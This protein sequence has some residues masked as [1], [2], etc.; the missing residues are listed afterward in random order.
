MRRKRRMLLP[1]VLACSAVFLVESAH[2]TGIDGGYVGTD[3][4]L[5]CHNGSPASDQT[6]F[7]KTGHPWKYKHTGGGSPSDPLSGLFPTPLI[8]TIQTTSLNDL[9]EGTP[10][11]AWSAIN[12]TIGGYG[13]KIRWG[14]LDHGQDSDGVNETGY[15][16]A[17]TQAQ[18]NIETGTWSGY[19]A[20]L[21]SNKK[22]ECATCHNTNGIVSTAGYS[23]WTDPGTDAAPTRTEPWGSNPGMGPDTHGGYYSSWT[24]DGVQCEG[25][26]GKGS[27]AGNTGH[28]NLG[29][30]ATQGVLTIPGPG[31]TTVE[32]CAK[33]HVRAENTASTGAE[34]GGD[35]NPAIL[36]NGAKIT[37]PWIGHHEQYNELTG[38]NGDG[39]HASLACTTC[40]D[41]HKRAAG[42][43]GAV[44][45]ALGISGD[46]T[47]SETGAIKK[48][49]A[50]CHGAQ[51]AADTASAVAKV[52]AHKNAGVTCVDCHMAEAT[53]TAT[54]SSTAGWGRKADLKTHIFKIDPA[55][56]SIVRPNGFTNVAQNYISPK[57]ACGKCH[58]SNI[59]G[60]AIA[61]PTSEAEAQ[62]AAADYHNVTGIDGGYV[63]S[64]ACSGCHADHYGDFVKSGHPYKVRT[65]NGATPNP[66]TDPL[67]ALLTSSGNNT[68][69]AVAALNADASLPIAQIDADGDGKLDW[70]SVQYV[71]G[72]FGWKA[73]WGILDSGTDCDQATYNPSCGTGYVWSAASLV[74]GYG[75]QFNM[76]AA[77]ITL[78]PTNKRADWS[79]YGSATGQS[80]KY[81]C[82]VCH[83]TNGKITSYDPDH[84]DCKASDVVATRTQPWAS[85]SLSF[86]NHGGFYSEWTFDGVQCEAC[87]GPAIDHVK[88]PSAS[89]IEKD[90]TKEACGKCH[91][92]ATN[93]AVTLGGKNDECGGD[94]NPEYLI[95]GA[96]STAGDFN[97]H[98]EQ[99]NELVGVTG[100]GAHAS[101]DC[102]DCHDPH[103][104]SHKVT[105]AIA[106]ALAI[107]DNEESAEDRGAVVSCE[108]C[109]GSKIL[110]YSMPGVECVDCHMA[111]VT[112]SGTG[113]KGAWGKMGDVK[114][115][116]FKIDPSQILNTRTNSA[117]KVVATNYLT[118]DYACGKCHDSSLSTYKFPALT[119][120]AAQQFAQGMHSAHAPSCAVTFSYTTVGL[121]LNPVAS[122]D[123][124]GAFTYDWD[125]GD[126]NS[127]PN[128]GATPPGHTYAAAGWHCTD[129]ISPDKATCQANNAVWTNT[130]TKSITLTVSNSEGTVGSVTRSVTVTAPDLP[131]TA[132]GSCTANNNT[133][134]ATLDTN[135]SSDDNGTPSVIVYWGDGSKQAVSA[136]PITH[137][138]V[139]AGSYTV[140]L[141][142]I[143]SAL[144]VNTSA[145]LCTAAP[146]PFTIGGTVY[147]SDG[148][149]PVASATVT[150]KTTVT[151]LGGGS[152]ITKIVKM[153]YT[154]SSGGFSVSG[155]KPGTY[156]LTVKKAHYTFADP[157]DTVT[158]GPSN[159]IRVINAVTP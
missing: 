129:G 8:S 2:A 37:D 52:V 142:A 62:T 102:V 156:T 42:V 65:T 82:A 21:P 103:K 157:S 9:I 137:T 28:A 27:N 46:N 22:Y 18:Y 79:T 127:S 141:K 20:T 150:V 80:K 90:V 58:D 39:V 94:S 87:H 13:W 35:A 1:A 85:S 56:S 140:T 158:V 108:S 15:V 149:T 53:K 17:G 29:A 153:V 132:A 48:A 44:A 5:S 89:N 71:I 96:P 135:T 38:L 12:Y 77:D 115:H 109:H 95:N 43:I 45:A 67:S 116:I 130:V 32:I 68:I 24:F 117:G 41:P 16:W 69:A 159:S 151:P 34:C 59:Y 131:P 57:Y 122:V 107:T 3:A 152:P 101:L 97:G 105:S 83:N 31:G 134:Q 7:T 121:T 92:R 25:C 118:V 111:E 66:S 64:Q 146:S 50:D 72:G 30:S 110:K 114:G 76:L 91:I 23:C 98:H 49:C 123:C 33:C 125:W 11:L 104:R 154:N 63:G 55:A 139:K 138:Y 86:A 128:A 113:E 145:T 54:N 144:Q 99:Y 19:P 112:K 61:G 106:S 73:R 70:A 26:H 74:G 47:K 143:D 133:W 4:C 75:A 155:L 147:K 40:H 93:T 51:A 36:A 88:S 14:V 119:R 136:T 124:S 120:A 81:Q 100:D 60:S 10:N 78:D 6:G 148:T 84:L 126:G